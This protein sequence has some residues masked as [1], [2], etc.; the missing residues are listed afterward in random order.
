[1]KRFIGTCLKAGHLFLTSPREAMTKTRERVRGKLDCCLEPYRRLR[2]STYVEAPFEGKITP[3]FS[4]TADEL[5]CEADIIRVLVTQTMDHRFDLLGSGWVQVHRNMSRD[6][7]HGHVYSGQQPDDSRPYTQWLPGHITPG[8]V[9][10]ACSVSK[11]ISSEYIPISWEEDFKSGFSWPVDQPRAALT[12]GD[13]PGVDVKVPWELSRMQHLPWLAFA[14]ILSR[15]GSPGFMK[16]EVYVQE[17]QDQVLDFI[18]ANPPQYGPNWL[19]TMDVAF[20]GVSLIAT[21]DFFRAAGFSFSSE[22]MYEFQ[23][24]IRDHGEHV[25]SHLEYDPT[26]RANHYYSDIVGLLYV[27]AWLPSVPT[28]DCWLAFA[29]QEFLCESKLQFH[30]DGTNFEASTSYHRLCSEMLVYG[31]SLLKGLPE[32]RIM[33]LQSYDH[34]LWK[35]IPHLAPSLGI[36]LSNYQFVLPDWLLQRIIRARQFA[37]DIR[38]PE[39]EVVQIGDNDSGRFLKLFPVVE[40]R[41]GVDVASAYE[42]L[43]HS[44][45]V[46]YPYEVVGDFQHLV[47][48]FDVFISS[49]VESNDTPSPEHRIVSRITGVL[50]S[51]SKQELSTLEDVI[52]SAYPDFGLWMWRRE[53][54]FLTMRCGHNG[55]YDN[56]GHAHNDQLSI[57]LAYGGMDFFVDPGT[58]LYTPFPAWRNQFRRTSAH[59]TV[60]TD[61]EQ[62]DFK[63]TTLF[64]MQDQA[65]PEV[66]RADENGFEGRH[67]GFGEEHI[68]S[69]DWGENGMRIIDQ[70]ADEGAVISIMLHPSVN[71]EKIDSK[72]IK[73]SRGDVGLLVTGLDWIIETSHFSPSYGWLQNTR[74]L[75]SLL[76]CNGATWFVHPF[77]FSRDIS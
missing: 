43:V 18:V 71:V 20:R 33:G 4:V 56:G 28:T 41:R 52:F 45:L 39:G 12:Y 34:S 50:S 51:E 66:V 27:A 24:S 32:Q 74:Q 36:D 13:L 48:I 25:V 21:F 57:T 16:P 30:E 59:N 23:R 10:H 53:G 64:S 55:Q 54:F 65:L 60:S 7:V 2:T 38:S 17:F 58:Y 14:A 35:H 8:N 31:A 6:G 3:F 68:R 73:L 69:I 15:A 29:I 47:A 77:N 49:K 22:F 9:K 37:L 75:K 63:E 46:D 62:N 1:M 40:V 11:Y 26:V 5:A 76:P 70:C 19:C 61:C 72:N 42:N 67:V 44:E